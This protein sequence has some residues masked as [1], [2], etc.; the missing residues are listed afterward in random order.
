MGINLIATQLSLSED[1]SLAFPLAARFQRCFM[2]QDAR[3][4]WAR[5]LFEELSV[6]GIFEGFE[7][8]DECCDVKSAKS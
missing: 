8:G 4:R 1:S 2:S 7:G 6:A 3:P 5:Q